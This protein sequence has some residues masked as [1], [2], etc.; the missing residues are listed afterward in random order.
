[1]AWGCEGGGDLGLIPTALPE[2][3]NA[4]H[5]GGFTASQGDPGL[6]WESHLSRR[7]V[8]SEG[9]DTSPARDPCLSG[10]MWPSLRSEE[11]SRGFI[12]ELSLRAGTQLALRCPCPKTEGRPCSGSP[13][14]V[15]SPGRGSDQRS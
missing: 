7:R 4:G 8:L 12:L 15:P 6:S 13:Q 1:M 14:G 5:P 11:G 2:A 9:G 3:G 10:E